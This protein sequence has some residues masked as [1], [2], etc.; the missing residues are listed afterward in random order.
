M[1]YTSTLSSFNFHISGSNDRLLSVMKLV[2]CVVDV[3]ASW[4]SVQTGHWYFVEISW[5]ADG[6]LELYVDL[7]KV[8][9]SSEPAQKPIDETTMTEIRLCVGCLNAPKNVS[10][11]FQRTPASA[12]IDELQICYGNCAKLTEFEFLQRGKLLREVL[13]SADFNCRVR[14][15]AKAQIPLRRLPRNFPGKST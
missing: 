9:N 14:A 7:K 10:D 8:A 5:S 13:K 12:I 1:V 2:R 3:Q 11:G 6:A 15:N 4:P